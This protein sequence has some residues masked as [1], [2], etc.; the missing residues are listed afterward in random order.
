MELF[1]FN[2]FK[3]FRFIDI[4]YIVGFILAISL[5]GYYL[6]QT[7]IISQDIA[8]DCIIICFYFR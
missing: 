4:E 7:G 6:I 3:K 8:N 5:W 2:L 1:I